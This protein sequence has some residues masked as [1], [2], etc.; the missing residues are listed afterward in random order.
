MTLPSSFA[1]STH[2][3][4]ESIRVVYD[5]AGGAGPPSDGKKKTGGQESG[6]NQHEMWWKTLRS[7][8]AE[9]C[10][11]MPQFS[12]SVYVNLN[13]MNDYLTTNSGIRR[14]D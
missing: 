8:I 3:Q 12:L 9:R 5:S 14:S 13:G 2:A 11:Y 10:V 4:T 1:A 7:D 6:E